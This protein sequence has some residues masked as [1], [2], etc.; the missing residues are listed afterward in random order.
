MPAGFASSTVIGLLTRGVLTTWLLI[1]TSL[2]MALVWGLPIS[3]DAPAAAAAA[4]TPLGTPNCP[5]ASAG[6]CKRV[7]L[8]IRPPSLRSPSTPV[9]SML[10]NI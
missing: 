9:A 3:G 8:E 2:A 6:P 10:A 1:T 4:F 5:A 7:N